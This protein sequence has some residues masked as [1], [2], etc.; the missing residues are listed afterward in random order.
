MLLWWRSVGCKEEGAVTA[1]WEDK[2]V[3]DCPE[4]RPDG[5][6]LPGF[7]VI[8]DGMAVMDEVVVVQDKYV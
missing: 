7:L 2:V 8:P 1:L 4:Q 3:H 5:H 6:A